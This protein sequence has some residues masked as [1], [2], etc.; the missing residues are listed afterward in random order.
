M[1]QIRDHK[2]HRLFI[3]LDPDLAGA[4]TAPSPWLASRT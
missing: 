1:M 2:I 3:Y 4:D